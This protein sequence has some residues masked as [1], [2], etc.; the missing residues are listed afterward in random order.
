MRTS[1]SYANSLGILNVIVNETSETTRMMIT[2]V[3]AGSTHVKQ[4]DVPI[5]PTVHPIY[6][7]LGM[8]RGN[9][10]R[11]GV[12]EFWYRSADV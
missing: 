10:A 5:G 3:I 7:R 2:V 6:P 12:C 9:G 11:T 8:I 4:V 1:N